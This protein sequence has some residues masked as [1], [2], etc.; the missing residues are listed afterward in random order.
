MNDDDN[1]LPPMRSLAFYHYCQR[2]NLTEKDYEDLLQEA[3]LMPQ[4]C[5]SNQSLFLGSLLHLLA[6][7]IDVLVV[8][9]EMITQAA[10]KHGSFH[11]ITFLLNSLFDEMNQTHLANEDDFLEIMNQVMDYISILRLHM[12]PGFI[13]AAHAYLWLDSCIKR[14]LQQNDR[15]LDQL[16]YPDFLYNAMLSISIAHELHD[17][18]FSEIYNAYGPNGL[19]SSNDYGCNDTNEMVGYVFRMFCSRHSSASS[20]YSLAHFQQAAQN[21]IQGLGP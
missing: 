19:R 4:L 20:N 6:C 21:V 7:E 9:K 18:S 3:G 5:L 16:N 14:L 12:T 1:S 10:I 17:I 15:A 13:L 2:V 11:S 8:K